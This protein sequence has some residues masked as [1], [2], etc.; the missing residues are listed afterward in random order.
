MKSAR[1]NTHQGHRLPLCRI[2]LL[3]VNLNLDSINHVHHNFHLKNELLDYLSCFNLFAPM[4][5]SKTTLQSREE[6]FFYGIAKK[7]LPSSLKLMAKARWKDGR[8]A[9]R[10]PD[11]IFLEEVAIPFFRDQKNVERVLDVG[12]DWYTWRYASLFPR[13][14][15][16]SIDFD[17]GKAK[18]A[19][20]TH[21]KG[22]LLELDQY[23]AEDQFDFVI[24]NGVFGWGINK[25]EEIRTAL[26]QIERCLRRGGFLVVGWNDNDE[27][28]PIGIEEELDDLFL[29][30]TLPPVGASFFDSQTKHRHLFRFYTAS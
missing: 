29:S 3:L 7:M 2:D 30:F 6:G 19:G 13:Q 26:A 22:S 12:T 17:P 21:V 11:R 8:I 9:L 18:F 23:F 14:E 10:I 28:R 16:H 24:C 20:K 27:R 25:R 5:I 4:T 1:M 15:Y